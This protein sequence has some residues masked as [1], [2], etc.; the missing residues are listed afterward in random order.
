MIL[1]IITAL[2]GLLFLLATFG[3]GGEGFPSAE[4]VYR[5]FRR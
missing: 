5:F 3:G 4:A 2:P 1:A